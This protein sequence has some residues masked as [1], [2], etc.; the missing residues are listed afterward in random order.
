M[1]KKE[2]LSF[3]GHDSFHCRS[4]W[5][6]KGID[7][8]QNNGQFNDNAV[9]ELG[10]GRNMVN[11]VRYWLRCF[12]MTDEQDNLNDI[13]RQIFDNTEGFDAYVEDKGTMWLLH[14]LLVTKG[15]ASIYSIVFNQ[16]RKERIEF[17]KEQL[18]Q[19]L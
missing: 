15:R 19:Y 10:V 9:V 5:L 12:D 3:T 17:S 1:S 16:F 13:A 8:I 14:Y 11:A 18:I 6:K 2:K 4:F 7:F